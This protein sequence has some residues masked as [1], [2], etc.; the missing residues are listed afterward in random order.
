MWHLAPHTLQRTAQVVDGLPKIPSNFSHFHCPYCNIAKLA[1][2]SGNPTSER[3]TVIPSTTFHIDLG[4]ICSPKMIKDN[5]VIPRPSKT[6]TTQQL[7]DGYLAYCVTRYLFCFPLKSRSPPLALINKFLNKNRHPQ[8]QVIRTSP[9][10]LLHKS[11]SFAE[12]CKKYGY[13]KNAHQILDELYEELLGMGP[14]RP[15]YY[16]C[17]DNGKKTCWLSRLLPTS[18]WQ[19]VHCG[20]HCTQFRTALV[21]AHTA[22]WK[23]KSVVS[24]TQRV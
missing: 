13:S 20:D 11:K 7:H 6:Q 21:N 19:Q 8:Q 16:I 14:E 5:I 1:K 3:K 10:S 18:K 4:F 24:C 17:M 22:H 23:I 9:N 2:K 12:V 15:L